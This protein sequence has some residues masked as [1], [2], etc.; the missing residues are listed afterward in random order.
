MKIDMD[1]F[2]KPRVNIDRFLVFKSRKY[3]IN[4]S[5]EFVSNGGGECNLIEMVQDDGED[6]KNKGKRKACHS[7]Y[8]HVKI[9]WHNGNEEIIKMVLKL[10]KKYQ[11]KILYYHDN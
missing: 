8:T 10:V 7:K 3:A 5:K 2:M 4:F 11:T 6:D 1:L 9:T